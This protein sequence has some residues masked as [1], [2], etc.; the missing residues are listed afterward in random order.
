MGAVLG[1]CT[2]AQCA[3]CCCPAAV[4]CCCA[5]C[6]SCN[7]STSTR[8]M[9]SIYLLL[10]TVVSCLM[11]STKIQEAMVEK[12]PFGLFDKACTA[13]GAG[14][15]CELLTG[16]LAVYR[17]CFAMACF[18]FFFMLITIGVKSSKDCRGGI[19]NGYWCIKFLILVG[20]CV[21]AFFIPR[22]DFGIVWMY[23]GFIGAFVFILIQMILLVDFAHTWNEIWTSNG[24]ESNNKMCLRTSGSSDKL[25]PSSGGTTGDAEEGSKVNEDEDEAV[26]YSY[27]FFHFVFFLASLYIMMTLTNWYSP[28]GST[29]ENFQRNWGS[30]WVKMVCTWLCHVIYI[31]TLVAPLCFP[32]RDFGN[33]PL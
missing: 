17:I 26:V 22:G 15:N 21:A 27:S 1:I 8:I 5:C 33:G 3:C 6:P 2:A 13:S 29:L 9:Y 23:I 19:H 16:Y 12:V 11:Y 32:D 14:T 24:E 28:Q 10:G 25:G 18:Y 20:L 30:V 4:G 31:W 7:S